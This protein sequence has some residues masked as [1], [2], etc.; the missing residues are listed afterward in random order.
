MFVAVII[1]PIIINEL[2]RMNRGYITVWDG[3]DVLTFYGAILGAMGT[4]ILGVV[5]SEQNKRLLKLE[6]TKYTLEIQPF[7]MLVAWET[8]ADRVYKP[9]ERAVQIAIGNPN[10][11]DVVLVLHFSNTTN[12]FLTAEFMELEYIDE[13]KSVGW[14]KGYIGAGNRKLI[15]QPNE[16]GQIAFIG[17]FEEFRKTFTKKIKFTFMLENRFGDKFTEDFDAVVSLLEHPN[18]NDRIICNAI[19]RCD[20]YHVKEYE[21]DSNAERRMKKHG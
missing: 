21:K 17:T 11:A 9:C 5:A 20:N 16:S 1:V 18:R 6:E 15:L 3:A 4:I 10:V 12:A 14:N 7:I 13:Q 2:Y 19:I 8:P